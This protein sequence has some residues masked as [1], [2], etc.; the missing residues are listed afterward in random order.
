M[1][2]IS[3]LGQSHAEGSGVDSDLSNEP[4]VAVLR[5]DRRAP[6]SLAVTHQLI[7]I[8]CP[9]WYLAD[10]PGL[11]HLPEFLQMGLG[12]GSRQASAERYR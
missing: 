11:Q 5:L 12:V 9:A 3:L 7:Q 1:G 4:V 2:V 6:Q 8:F 10:H